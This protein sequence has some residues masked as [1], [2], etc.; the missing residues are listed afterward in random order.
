M[1]KIKTLVIEKE[2][3]IVEA[4]TPYDLAS[5]VTKYINTGVWLLVGGPYGIYN[6]DQNSEMH[7]QA[8]VKM[9]KKEEPSKNVIKFTPKINP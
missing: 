3:T 7:F 5:E 9:F 8:L 1:S 2:Y 6:P 4:F